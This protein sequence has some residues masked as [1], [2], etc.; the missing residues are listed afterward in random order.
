[1]NNLRSLIKTLFHIVSKA[2]KDP[3]LIKK[4]LNRKVFNRIF[5]STLKKETY[6]IFINPT[7]F[8]ILSFP[9]VDKPLV[10]VIIPV[11]NKWEYTYACLATLL[12]NTHDVSYEVILGDDQSSDETIN[13]S[14]Y[15]ENIKILRHQINQRFVKNCNRSAELARGKYIVLLNNDTN[16]QEEWLST[17]I[18]LAESD[19]KI[20]VVGSK[21]IYPDGRLQEAG[22]LLL[23]DGTAEN[24][25]SLENPYNHEYSY[26]REVDYVSG[27][28]YLV[29]KELWDQL[30]GFDEDLTPGYYEDTDFCFRAREAGYK[31][32]Y[33]PLSRLIHY[34]GVSHGTST[35]TGLKAYQIVNKQ[36]F[37]TKWKDILNKH[38]IS[39]D[40]PRFKA[41]DRAITKKTLIVID[42]RVPLYDQDAGSRSTFGY[43]KLFLKMGFQVKFIA[44]SLTHY[45]PYTTVLEQMGIEVVYG[46][47]DNAKQWIIQNGKFFDYVYIHRPD[48]ANEYLDHI[49]KHSK[50]KIWYQTHDLHYLRERR[51]YAIEKSKDALERSDYYRKLEGT[52]CKKV[53]VVLTFSEFEKEIIQKEFHMDN[54]AVI[55]LYIY[56]RFEENVTNTME[57]INDLLFVG[58]FGHLPNRQG[59]QWFM[60]EVFPQLQEKYKDIS[61]TIVGSNPPPEIAALASTHVTVL[62]NVSDDTL[63][64]LHDNS[65]ILIVPLLY[66]AGIKGKVVDALASGVPMVST[67][68]GIEGLL[69]ISKIIPASDSPVAFRQQ[70]EGLLSSDKTREHLSE[71][72]IKYAKEHFSFPVA[73]AVIKKIYSV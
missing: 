36:K 42:S 73:E 33:Q 45:E 69:D 56:E 26:V 16:V 22:G 30:G 64:K 35:S 32:M 31:V 10:S 40:G 27:A 20:G 47:A 21:L 8:P 72:Y 63:K 55:P 41:K 59:I 49:K 61:L 71:K 23:Q 44:N 43:L 6:D 29:R 11:Y 19:T 24:I 53:D 14:K 46:A 51:R 2:L 7:E 38:H 39:A 60:K 66:G 68:I 67:S 58:G 17:M 1:M 5:T 9:K 52:I 50:A 15:A 62:S 57:K 28:S 48:I 13:A 18:R 4:N 54:V 3:T 70:L 25:G 12:R 37:Y 34:E 65:K